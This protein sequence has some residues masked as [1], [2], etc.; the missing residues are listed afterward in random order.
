MQADKLLY[1]ED[2]NTYI[3]GNT[4]GMTIESD[5]LL[6]MNAD[7]SATI[8][9]PLT[10]ITGN[11]DVGSGVDVTGSITCSLDLNIEGDIDMA[12]GKKVAWVDNS[13]YISGTTTGIT[14]E[15][16]DTLQV[17]ADTSVTFTTPQ[18]TIS[19]NLDI[20]SGLDVTGLI[21]GSGSIDIGD[22]IDMATGKKITWVDDNQYISGT[23]TGITIESDDTLQVNADTSFTAT[24]PLFYLY[25]TAPE[26][27]IK[28]TNTSDGV[29]LLTMIGDNGT[30]V[31]DGWQVK[32]DT[33]VMTFS[34]D[35]NSKGTYNRTILTLNGNN[36]I[37]SSTIDV[38]GH[39]NVAS[40][41]NIE[42]DIDM[43]TGKKITWVD[44]NQYISGT[45][46]GITIESDDT[47]QVN[48]DT[49]V[50][51]LTPSTII[52]SGLTVDL[53]IKATYT[54]DGVATITMICD[55]GQ[56]L[57]DGWQIKSLSGNL[58]FSSD[59]ETNET[60]TTEILKL[61]NH[62]TQASRHVEV[63]GKLSVTDNIV[64]SDGGSITE[65]GG[66]AAITI[67][68]SGEVTKI[69]QDTPSDG[70]VLTWDNSNSKVVW[71]D[72]S[73]GSISSISNF[74][75]NRII[76]ASGSD[77]LNGEANLTFNGSTLNVVGTISCDTSLTID[78]TVLDASD[79]SHIADITE[80]AVTASKALVVD[81]SKD[82][83]TLNIVT[84]AELKTVTNTNLS[85]DPHG[86]GVVIFKGNATRGA[87]QFK[88]NC[89]NN[90]H[91]ITIKGPAHSAAATYT[92]VLP[93]TDGGVNE[94]LK[95]DGSGNLSW[96]TNHTTAFT[97][98]SG[99]GGAIGLVPAPSSG[100]AAAGKYLKADGTWATVSG[101]G[102]GGIS[103]DGSTANGML[104][105]KDS[106]EATVESNI[107]FDGSTLA[108]GGSL[109]LNKAQGSGDVTIEFKQAGTTTYVMGIDD[110]STNNVFKIHSSTSL[111]DNSDFTIDT[112]GN[113]TVGG[114][115]ILDDGGSIKEAGG[116]AAIT[117]D[118]AGEVSKIG[119]DTPTDGQV[120]TW[121]NGNSKVVW[122]TVSGGGGG[123][124]PSG[125]TYTGSGASAEFQVTGNIR[126]TADITA[127]HTSDR[128]YK[129]NLKNIEK[130]NEKLKRIN[131]Y[132][133]DWNDKHEVYKNTHDIGVIAQEIEE[134]LPEIVVEREDGYK[135]VRYEKIIPLLIESN[136]DLVQRVEGLEQTIKEK[137]EKYEELEKRMK[138][139]EE[140]LL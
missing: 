23:A 68:A 46:T 138:K 133:F 52:Q 80:G 31:G 109:T 107:T 8:T 40:D 137:D 56:D 70:Q 132:E 30:D 59:H 76:T 74:S 89:E 106:D 140:L 71:S 79:I 99:S 136:K 18:T 82:I 22:D 96:A 113:V 47:L 51:M 130:P 39:L 35:H 135:A 13:Q 42:G 17:Y 122:S 84:L 16:D 49:S 116:T 98:D 118:S 110:S 108:V 64:L 134:V 88:L 92:L 1:W 11:L 24:T 73:S 7:T 95:S 26:I 72:A 3:T 54:Y 124:L 78:S 101:G 129:D 69:G 66:V 117:I 94:V 38:A 28:S 86:S 45:A 111:V 5:D 55:N 139:L 4:T 9:T 14:I 85:I 41:L 105:Y 2:T 114:D 58:S 87:G 63:F 61:T 121:D 19:G 32:T 65:S 33:G 21:T 10:T 20:S 120:L 112:S 25:S 100:D 127:Y 27:R 36:V 53:M 131:G 83:G 15:S 128:R 91:G 37:T 77:T 12:S 81:S 75:D 57:G 34:S 44:D 62:A 104:T 29:P 48:A 43:A 115:L 60:Y 90:S 103:F 125:V 119:Q 102:G 93:T 123:G 6:V 97:G 126:A 50:T 67:D